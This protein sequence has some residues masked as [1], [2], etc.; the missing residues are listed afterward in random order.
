MTTPLFQTLAQLLL[1]NNKGQPIQ[2]VAEYK[3]LG[4]VLDN[5]LKWDKSTE[6]INKK[7]QQRLYFLKKL[8]LFDV[9]LSMLKMFYSAFVESVLTFGLTCWFGNATEAQKKTLR[10]TVTVASKLL[11]FKLTSLEDIYRSRSLTK[12]EKII[13]DH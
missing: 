7:S 1:I 3:Y 12:A 6:L 10:K 11:G 5:K 13:A 4:V 8:V 9:N 2:S